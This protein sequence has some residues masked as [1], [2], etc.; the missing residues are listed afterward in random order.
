MNLVSFLFRYEEEEGEEEE[1][2]EMPWSSYVTHAHAWIGMDWNVLF[3]KLFDPA[4]VLEVQV[5]GYS[6]EV[7]WQESACQNQFDEQ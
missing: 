5:R 3:E 1:E 6:R 4:V 7:S 2:D